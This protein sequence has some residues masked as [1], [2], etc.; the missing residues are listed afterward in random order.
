MPHSWCTAVKKLRIVTVG[1][2]VE[3]SSRGRFATPADFP[4]RDCSPYESQGCVPRSRTLFCRPVPSPSRC[5]DSQLCELNGAHRE[6]TGGVVEQVAV[7]LSARS[8]LGA[9]ALAVRHRAQSAP[10]RRLREC[11]AR[12][13]PR[14]CHCEGGEQRIPPCEGGTM[15]HPVQ[16]TGEVGLGAAHRVAGAAGYWAPL[17]SRCS[18]SPARAAQCVARERERRRVDLVGSHARVATAK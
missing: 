12:G 15:P 4:L 8:A 6:R 9:R 2:R 5:H 3:I 10:R 11:G 14:R 16:R 1:I 13:R 17:S 7:G 18:S